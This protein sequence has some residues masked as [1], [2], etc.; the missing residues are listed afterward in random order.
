MHPLAPANVIEILY[1][2]AVGA[3]VG[4]EREHAV[5]SVEGERPPGAAAPLPTGVLGLRSFALLSMLGWLAAYLSGGVAWLFPA[6]L[7]V[8]GVLLATW[9]ARGSDSGLSTEIAAVTTFC[10]GYLVREDRLLAVVLSLL[11]TMLLVAKP[12]TRAFVLRLRRVEI[13][14]T[15]QLL[16]LAAVVLPLLPTEAVDPWGTLPPRKVGVFVML[17]AAISYVGYVLTRV[18][19][20]RRSAGLTGAVGGLASSTAVTAAMAADARR[21]PQMVIP[22]QLATFL[23]NTVMCARVVVV[24]SL[25]ARDVAVDI[26]RPMAVMALG[27]LAGAAWKWAM[28]RRDRSAPESFANVPQLGNPFA[29]LPAL[30]WGA[31]LCVVLI[32]AEGAQRLF[33]DRGLYAAAGAS[34]IAD[35]DAIT[36][37]V[38]RR[39]ADG[40]LARATAVLAVTIAVSSN[41]L[42]KSGIALVGGGVRFGRDVAIVLMAATLA[43]VVVAAL[44]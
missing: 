17:V 20:A 12:W 32:L 42:V 28:L 1:A 19:G 40:S 30:K 7:L 5:T 35:V 37:A 11:T 24:T 38:A 16:L 13:T 3:I 25:V 4:L 23:A 27:L 8:V 15:L 21:D 29:L 41:A 33:G 18:M 43:G 44:G 26:A 31:L 10:L 2:F 39:A 14:G 22:G 36:L 9:H 6:M 34:G